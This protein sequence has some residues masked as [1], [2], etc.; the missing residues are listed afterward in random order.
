MALEKN[1][2]VKVIKGIYE[3]KIGRLIRVY[4][5]VD[6]GVVDFDDGEI[7]KVN[8]SSLTET[9]PE[10][11]PEITRRAREIQEIEESLV[12]G[13]KISKADFDAA[14]AKITNPTVLFSAPDADPIRVLV[15]GMTAKLVGVRV[16]M[17]L[18]EDGSDVVVI[19]EDH[20]ISLLWDVCNPANI[21]DTI[22]K[23]MDNRKCIAV[24]LAAMITL[25]DLVPVLF[26]GS[27]D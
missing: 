18:F 3:G 23:K 14:L 19:S 21:S 4:K 2:T 17:R 27:Y 22:G 6:V 15:E 10:T 12:G 25:K 26:G 20:F 5:E 9:E 7:G 11:E 8:L 1:A 24:A 16:G 13:H